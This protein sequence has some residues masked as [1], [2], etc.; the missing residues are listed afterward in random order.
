M[1]SN[2]RLHVL[3]KRGDCDIFGDYMDMRK[4]LK[5]IATACVGQETREVI[6]AAM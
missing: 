5:S 1:S 6:S 2:R 4:L 3:R